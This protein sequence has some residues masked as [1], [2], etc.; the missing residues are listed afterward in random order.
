MI[1]CVG[2]N[3]E[4]TGG[5]PISLEIPLF[6]IFE[7]VPRFVNSFDVIPILDFNNLQFRQDSLVGQRLEQALDIFSRPFT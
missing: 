3:S 5:I 4:P 2:F 7:A 6:P 1:M